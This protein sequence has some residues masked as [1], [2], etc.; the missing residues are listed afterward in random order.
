MK[1][2]ELRARSIAAP[3]KAVKPDEPR[4]GI[5]APAKAMKT[6][7]SPSAIARAM[8]R[9]KYP[10]TTVGNKALKYEALNEGDEKARDEMVLRYLEFCTTRYFGTHNFSSNFSE[11]FIEDPKRDFKKFLKW[12]GLKSKILNNMG[13]AWVLFHVFGDE[14]QKQFPHVVQAIQKS[15]EQDKNSI[16]QYTMGLMHQMGYGVE[17][18]PAKAEEYYLMAAKQ[19]H[20]PSQ[21]EL[22]IIYQ[23]NNL[24]K[25]TKWTYK[26]A[27]QGDDVARNNYA[28]I[29]SHDQGA[30]IKDGLEAVLWL[31]KAAEQRDTK[32]LYEWGCKNIEIEPGLLNSME[33]LEMA[34]EQNYVPALFRL[35]EMY[36][37]G[38]VVRQDS[39]KATQLF[40]GVADHW[41]R[42]ET[43]QNNP[44]PLTE[45]AVAQTQLAFMLVTYPDQ[46]EYSGEAIQL[47]R[48]AA[49]HLSRVETDQNNAIPPTV[50]ATI[51]TQLALMLLSY[52]DQEEYSVEALGLVDKIANF[53]VICQLNAPEEAAK[54][55][56]WAAELRHVAA[57]HKLGVKYQPNDPEKSADLIRKA[58][59]QD[60]AAAQRDLGFMHYKINNPEEGLKWI[61]RAAAI[62]DQRSPDIHAVNFLAERYRDGNGVGVGK[63]PKKAVK[64]FRKVVDHWLH[65]KNAKKKAV[66][67]IQAL[68][69]EMAYMA[70]MQL[71]FMLL[72]FPETEK[73]P[74]EAVNLSTKLIECE[75]AKNFPE[76]DSALMS[77][78]ASCLPNLA[79]HLKEV[80]NAKRGNAD[81]Q[82]ELGWRAKCENWPFSAAEWF[83]KAAAQDH[84]YAQFYL[85]EMYRDGFDPMYKNNKVKE[86]LPP[87]LTTGCATNVVVR[88]SKKAIQFFR[89]VIDHSAKGD[90]NKPIPIEMA[91]KAQ[92]HLAFLLLNSPDEEKDSGEAMELANRAATEAHDHG[93]SLLN[94]PAHSAK[95]TLWAAGLRHAAAMV[96]NKPGLK[97]QP[98][99]LDA[100]ALLEM[101]LSGKEERVDPIAEQELGG[102]RS[103]DPEGAAILEQYIREEEKGVIPMTEYELGV[104]HFRFHDPEGG[105]EWIKRAA[106]NGLAEAKSFL[107]KLSFRRSF[108]VTG[109]LLNEG[110]T[111]PAVKLNQISPAELVRIVQSKSDSVTKEPEEKETLPQTVVD[112]G[113][114]LAQAELSSIF[115]NNVVKVF[116]AS[117]VKD[118]EEEGTLPQT[119]A[120]Q[121]DSPAQ[122][123]LDKLKLERKKK[124]PKRNQ[125]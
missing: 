45:L 84:V 53:G 19:G 75:E 87:T 60:D 62:R 80:V 103:Y 56:L 48:R 92:I 31:R 111:I 74:G 59:T 85:A 32:A 121:V 102:I 38:E 5:P 7:E 12:P 29:F 114:A 46:E 82:F 57:Q 104:M 30:H 17:Q 44:V 72:D 4:A 124:P 112:Q 70:Q 95:W 35:A 77:K 11:K 14:Y 9:E 16:A 120:E 101:R 89:N 66:P 67:S 122:A 61:Q 28:W 20:A 86:G 25:A 23:P 40:R 64:L 22:G 54:W 96:Q 55:T 18:S 51:Q 110:L 13:Y 21:R 76:A 117:V 79:N 125:K 3:P 91:L 27:A 98:F 107:M 88:N 6:D 50:L 109:A 52:S 94:N 78:F 15:A 71:A 81:A 63:D 118:P 37:D 26:A 43:D 65:E 90:Q 36:R 2:G 93:L 34:A 68:R 69:G 100:L 1:P 49:N 123:E 116:N 47:L 42:V 41:S 24:K 39:K 106:E 108:K 119:A 8:M 99:H 97:Y 105:V 115:S 10:L 58:I 113:D 73:S 83:G 33:C